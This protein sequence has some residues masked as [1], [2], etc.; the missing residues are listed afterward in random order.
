VSLCEFGNQS[1]Q[2]GNIFG[3]KMVCRSRPNHGDAAGQEIWSLKPLRLSL[4][5]PVLVWFAR[6][7]SRLPRGL[8]NSADR[9][10]RTRVLAWRRVVNPRWTQRSN[11]MRAYPR[12]VHHS[13]RNR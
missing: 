12:S 5:E 1:I 9:T 8:G 4:S 7:R 11:S 2:R 10:I 3:V 6:K 13:A